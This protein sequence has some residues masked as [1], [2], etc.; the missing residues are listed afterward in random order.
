[1]ALVAL[2]YGAVSGIDLDRST[3]GALAAALA[4]LVASVGVGR[5]LL[6]LLRCVRTGLLLFSLRDFAVAAALASVLGGAPAALV[7]AVYGPAMLLAA[8]VL[9]TRG[10]RH[11]PCGA[12][13]CCPVDAAH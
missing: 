3:L 4:F 6:P 7:P 10:R 13:G 5:L 8:S 9:A 2:I 11:G 12:P 1:M